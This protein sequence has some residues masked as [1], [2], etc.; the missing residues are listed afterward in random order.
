MME[1]IS[2]AQCLRCDG[3]MVHT[4][5]EKIQLGEAGWIF[6]NISNVFAGT[7]EVEIYACKKCGKT[8]FFQD[9][10][11]FDEIENEEEI[12]QMTCPECGHIHD[13]DYPK[14]PACKHN[15][16]YEQE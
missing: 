15:Y 2:K 7:L 6:G 8:E 3:E 14:C 13:M 1:L 4:G 11:N 9:P 12:A 16:Q 5:T 10:N